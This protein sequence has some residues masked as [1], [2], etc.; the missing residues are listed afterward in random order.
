MQQK[1]LKEE[2][3]W[4]GQNLKKLKYHFERKVEQV[5]KDEIIDMLINIQT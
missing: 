1:Y 4:N 5:Q 3:Q 2:D